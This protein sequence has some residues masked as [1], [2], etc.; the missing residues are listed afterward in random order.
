M[1]LLAAISA[2]GLAALTSVIAPSASSAD[3][4]TIPC[5]QSI[6]TTKFPYLGSSRPE[7]R[8]RQVLGVVAVPPAYMRQVV[9][10]NQKP[11]AYWHKQGIVI[12]ATG[13]LVTVSVPARWRN[14]AAITWGNGIGPVRSLRIQACRTSADVGHAFAGGFLLRSR[15][16]CI[17]LIFRVGKRTATVRFGVGQ[18]CRR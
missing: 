2:V 8:Y 9:P 1:R 18:R 5:A 15:A 3:G 4:R 17:P 12:R 14:L 6:A 10:T 7:G 13:Q 16:A 11:W